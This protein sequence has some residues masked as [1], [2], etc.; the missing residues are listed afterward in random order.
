MDFLLSPPS[1]RRNLWRAD[2]EHLPSALARRF[3]CTGEACAHTR[4]RDAA[5]RL[6]PRP[7]GV[8]PSASSEA[9]R[10][11]PR[12]FAAARCRPLM[13]EVAKRSFDRGR[14]NYAGRVSLRQPLWLTEKK[15][16]GE[17]F[18]RY[19]SPPDCRTYFPA[20]SVSKVFRPLRR[21]PRASPL[22]PTAFEKAAET[23]C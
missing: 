13:R 10:T 9:R 20:L 17:G 15:T 3:S 8:F 5:V 19:N 2:W 18:L 23:L 6:V 4:L 11:I 1:G 21:T 7:A 14:E 16:P 22:D 12:T